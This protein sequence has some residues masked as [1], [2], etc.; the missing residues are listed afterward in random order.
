MLLITL[1][2]IRGVGSVIKAPIYG[3]WRW[4]SGAGVVCLFVGSVAYAAPPAD[5][6][7]IF[8]TTCMAC[9]GSRGEG[10]T[11]IGAPNIAG[12]E[13]V[14][15]GRQL[16][17]FLSGVR[18]ASA[19]DSYGSQMRAAVGVLK[20]DADRIAV[21]SYIASLPQIKS[22]TE[23]KINDGKVNMA[24]GSTQYN[25]VCSSCHES[26]AQGNAQMGAPSLVGID[27]VYL[28]RQVIAF[29]EG[30]RGAHKDDKTGALMRVGANMLPDAKS[31]HD[32]IAYIN[33]LKP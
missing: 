12:M 22:T 29:R 32:V 4:V 15:V 5:G 24:N 18:G 14:Y 26:R 17:N 6:K 9:H 10:N 8:S 1:S 20:T 27:P 33:H 2:W 25:A 16:S 28:E 30:S 19:N 7:A 31:A 23:I 11:K 21:A 13:A 3:C